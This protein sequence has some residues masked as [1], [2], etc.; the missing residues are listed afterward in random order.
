M[1][2]SMTYGGC[3]A[4]VDEGDETFEFMKMKA[5]TLALMLSTESGKVIL[6]SSKLSFSSAL[7]FILLASCL[8]LLLDFSF[9]LCTLAELVNLE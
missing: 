7:F 5:T 8:L 6:T 3:E 9:E 1:T 4:A 2:I